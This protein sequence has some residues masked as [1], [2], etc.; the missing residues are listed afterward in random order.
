MNYASFPKLGL[1]PHPSQ[2]QQV[3]DLYR[4][5]IRPKRIH[6]SSLDTFLTLCANLGHAKYP[7]KTPLNRSYWSQHKEYGIHP[8]IV[9]QVKAMRKADYLDWDKGCETWERPTTVTATDKF[10]EY[11]NGRLHI[12]FKPQQWI[13]ARKRIKTDERRQVWNVVYKRYEIEP[14]F[15]YDYYNFKSNGMTRRIER[16]L[17]A[18]YNLN[19][20]HS[21]TLN[22]NPIVT[23][24][25]CIFSNQELTS[26]GRLYT[27][28]S[29]GTQRHSKK[30]REDILIDDNETVELDYASLHIN[31][32]RS[33]EGLRPVDDAYTMVLD[34]IPSLSSEYH[35]E[36]R[37]FL[38][39]L[40]QSMLNVDIRYK[41]V[42]S[43]NYA[44]NYEP[45]LELFRKDP[46]HEITD[47]DRKVRTILQEVNLSVK[48]LVSLFENTHHEI[49]HHFYSGIGLTLQNYDSKIAL[50]LLDYFTNKR[51]IMLPIH[52]SFVVGRA[53]SALLKEK[54]NK[55]YK[56]V[57]N[58][59]H[60]CPIK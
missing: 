2:Q 47:N 49:K 12:D 48:E 44:T 19:H 14:V 11:F 4:E 31:M 27:S 16:I 60:E 24:L 29:Y 46:D 58:S 52:D 23:S 18:S 32:L 21:I 30:T 13:I 50:K 53:S 36:L 40:L 38:K 17:Q 28:T 33:M 37:V 10:H 41:A 39:G 59:I 43:G 7:I 20:R 26:G 25:R 42:K 57:M 1:F 56:E 54:M 8:A 15:K 55:A 3:I 22:G 51:I 9:D 6:Q 5:V 34:K 35:K 45:L